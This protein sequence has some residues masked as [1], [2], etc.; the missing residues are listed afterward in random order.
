MFLLQKQTVFCFGDFLTGD[1]SPSRRARVSAEQHVRKLLNDFA[2]FHLFRLFR[3]LRLLV[4]LRPAG[5]N[6]SQFC[7]QVLFFINS[8]AV[9]SN[10]RLTDG[11]CCTEHTAARS[12]SHCCLQCVNN[13]TDHFIMTG[14]L[15]L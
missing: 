10:P 15:E 9:L 14:Q 2:L 7:L 12:E 5:R 13:W 4:F 11:C 1:K 8:T 3:Q 6:C